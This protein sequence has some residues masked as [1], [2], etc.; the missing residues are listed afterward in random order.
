MISVNWCG[1]LARQPRSRHG[2][3][4]ERYPLLRTVWRN[5]TYLFAD[6]NLFLDKNT[7]ERKTAAEAIPETHNAS[8]TLRA[9]VASL[10]LLTNG[11]VIPYVLLAT[12]SLS[13]LSSSLPPLARAREIKLQRKKFSKK[14]T[15]ATVFFHI[16]TFPNLPS[17]YSVSS[18]SLSPCCLG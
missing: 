2:R 18:L 5:W 6:F 15:H 13:P 10:R 8:G 12:L 7:K 16:S 9:S 4:V 11:Q 3:K 17:P 1:S 14:Q